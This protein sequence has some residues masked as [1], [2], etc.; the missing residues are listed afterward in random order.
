MGSFVRINDCVVTELILHG[1]VRCPLIT[2]R[3]RK[4]KVD[5]RPLAYLCCTMRKAAQTEAA[6]FTSTT[7]TTI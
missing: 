7:V 5:N 3:T 1:S 6:N 2:Y 4:C